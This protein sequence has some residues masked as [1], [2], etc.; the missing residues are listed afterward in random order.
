MAAGTTARRSSKPEQL[1]GRD[2]SS[3]LKTGLS[4]PKV[5]PSGQRPHEFCARAGEKSKERSESLL[6]DN[7]VLAVLREGRKRQ[8][9]ERGK[10]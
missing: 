10:G 1:A 4:S 5:D 6:M 9:S 7:M 3:G 8:T 2:G